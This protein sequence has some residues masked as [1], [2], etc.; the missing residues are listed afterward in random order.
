MMRLSNA[1]TFPFR[2]NQRYNVHEIF[3]V[4]YKEFKEL[5]KKLWR[6]PLN[7][8]LAF[9]A[10]AGLA[11]VQKMSGST[12]LLGIV[13]LWVS[14]TFLIVSTAWLVFRAGRTLYGESPPLEGVTAIG[15]RG[16][17]PFTE[18][19]GSLFWNLGR[20]NEVR[21]LLASVENTYSAITVLHGEDGAGKTSVLWA[22]L[23]PVLKQRDIQCAY[24]DA[25]V[26][27]P[28]AAVR[29]AIFNELKVDVGRNV[30]E[31]AKIQTRSVLILDSFEQLDVDRPEHA[32]L[33]TLLQALNG[34]S[35]PY[36]LQV[37]VAYRDD[38]RARWFDIER[39][40]GIRANH[41][42]L[43]LLS[44]DDAIKA[45]E[46]I[47]EE[48]GIN[49]DRSIIRGYVR[50]ATG[51]SGVSP[52]D[53]AV[54]A[55]IF[56]S[57]ARR[58]PKQH[59]HS[60]EYASTGGALGVLMA[61]V[62]ARLDDSYILKE[63]RPALIR[64]LANAFVADNDEGRNLSGVSSAELAAITGLNVDLLSN[65]YLPRLASR[66][67]R[68]L[69]TVSGQGSTKYRL[70]RDSMAI[71]LKQLAHELSNT[72]TR[73]ELFFLE[74]YGWWRRT[75]RKRDCL[76]G[77]LLKM[78]IQSLE[79]GHIYNVE[80]SSYIRK[81]RTASRIRHARNLSGALIVTVLL[82]SLLVFGATKI[83]ELKL[84]SWRLPPDLYEHQGQLDSLRIQ[85]YSV[86]ELEWLKANNYRKLEISDSRLTSIAGLSNSRT[87]EDLTIDLTETP[88]ESLK[89]VARIPGLT[90]LTV[91]LGR[92][93]VDNLSDLQ[94]ATKLTTVSL[95]LGGSSINSLNELGKM[96]LKHVTLHLAGSA[97]HDLTPLK[98]IRTLDTLDLHLEST[99]L[100][101]VADL[102]GADSVH[103]LTLNIENPRNVHE[104]SAVRELPSLAG[105]QNVTDLR[106]KLVPSPDQ[107][108]LPADALV[109]PIGNLDRLSLPAQLV[110]LNIDVGRFPVA[111][112]PEVRHL[113]NLVHLGLHLQGSG[114][115]R[116]P[117]F[118]SFHQLTE[119]EL[120]L[121]TTQMGGLQL[122]NLNSLG[123]V[124]LALM[125]EDITSLPAL[126]GHNQLRN[127]AL[128][129]SHTS[130]S[131]LGV[132]ATLRS[133]GTLELHLKPSQLEKLPSLAA[134][135]DLG[136]VS[137]YVVGET[138]RE[139]PALGISHDLSTLTLGFSGSS[140]DRLPPLA[141]FKNV[142][143]LS[144]SLVG[145]RINTL[146]EITKLSTLNTLTL[147][148]SD[149]Q[150]LQIL[151]DF[152][153]FHDLS[154]LTLVLDG[155]SL[156]SLPDMSDLK[157]LSTLTINLRNSHITDI[158]QFRRLLTLQDLTLDQNF[159]SLDGLPQSVRR[160]AF[161][162]RH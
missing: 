116:L 29:N 113:A 60:E 122:A 91:F 137:L 70:S 75:Q 131:D 90:T 72:S 1:V 42:P 100:A 32:P 50:T 102:N 19:D 144:L 31:A 37:I 20:I 25:A 66:N 59:L 28:V 125:G 6:S 68:I 149:V 23:K 83:Q 151:P 109:P 4:S 104:I 106:L 111:G 121:D 41:Q 135:S 17:I 162:W 142:K 49:V 117:E 107:A 36:S 3:N 156:R 63:D 119:L 154:D 43:G 92:S 55:Q 138:L 89:D 9:A 159:S 145:S 69:E 18:K 8:I 84:Q 152:T 126:P 112:L 76:S 140:M 47:L 10:I 15:A 24:C 161:S 120:A 160:L 56:E 14:V 133:L 98:Q 53:V 103:H 93:K 155:S 96:P 26:N 44:Q 54:G 123:I 150:R 77:E 88:V 40:T 62:E 158:V 12:A 114:I 71:V 118:R 30:E 2:N 35:A 108:F 97:I 58:L 78:A 99:Q 73:T 128:D 48:A 34:Q 65:D 16:L 105:M 110:R 132:L 134:L 95:Y 82:A 79:S 86:S 27:D 57:W 146:D 38:Y 129:V 80:L 130:I 101:L 139:L 87:I 124:K 115:R 5:I 22:G 81:S 74:Q 61:H 153:Q 33:F 46:T 64:G 51:T 13:G 136:T 21:R 39:R 7:D 45:L 52:V 85:G 11:G 67:S 147:D 143:N 141:Q 148:V 94:Q 127:V 157:R